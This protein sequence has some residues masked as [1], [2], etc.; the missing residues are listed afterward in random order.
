MHRI[1]GYVGVRR[2]QF[3]R[4]LLP[5]YG[6]S[7]I[8][9]WIRG[10]SFPRV[11]AVRF[12]DLRRTSPISRH[13]GYDRG[14]P[15]DRYYIENFL[16]TN[17]H[18]IRGWVLEIGHDTYT[19]RYG[20][21]VTHSDVLHIEAGHPRV[22]IVADLSDADHLPG[23]TYD[24]IIFTQTLHLI[25]DMRPVIQT[26]HRMLRPGG[27]LL[28]TFPGIS[29][30]DAGRWADQW[31]WSLTSHSARRLFGDSF[32]GEV[33]VEG[34]GNV[35]AAIAFLHGL[36]VGDVDPHELDVRDPAYD[37]LITVRATKAAPGNVP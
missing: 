21:G 15:I 9:R 7:R 35:L 28:A 32:Q 6:G 31:F 29:N 26:L 24:A 23:D 14:R 8:R 20:S 1:R 34:H 19:R 18:L 5:G 11:G 2:R 25:F 36:A 3:L 4:R 33:V 22:T 13:F 12:G 10:R 27:V 37:V 17:A 30:I 16:A